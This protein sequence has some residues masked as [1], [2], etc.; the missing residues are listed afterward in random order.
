[1]DVALQ[2]LR[3]L[4]PHGAAFDPAALEAWEQNLHG[5]E[6]KFQHRSEQ[7]QLALDDAYHQAEAAATEERRYAAEAAALATREAELARREEEVASRKATLDTRAWV[8]TER[9]EAAHREAANAAAEVK[10][11]ARDRATAAVLDAA[12][13]VK[14]VQTLLEGE[15]QEAARRVIA[16]EAA[17]ID[18]ETRTSTAE[19]RVTR[20]ETAALEAVR[21]DPSADLP[22]A[23]GQ[24][25][26]LADGVRALTH[27]FQEVWEQ[28]GLGE[29]EFAPRGD[30][31]LG[32]LCLLPKMEL[33]GVQQ[34][35]LFS[36]RPSRRVPSHWPWRR[37]SLR[38]AACGPASPT[39]PWRR[40]RRALSAG[41]R[42]RRVPGLKSWQGRW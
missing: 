20:L 41:S 15:L 38:W 30:P 29:V 28:T 19:E 4:Q 6:A 16:A 36:S 10:R 42:W 14:D 27:R 25:C 18:A 26:Q 7:L 40:P 5:R 9:E 12:T 24:L 1:M 3:E 17:A 8:L 33:L 22:W 37:C 35:E 23:L 21:T 32:E 11:E 2:G 34:G 31:A 13:K 39:S